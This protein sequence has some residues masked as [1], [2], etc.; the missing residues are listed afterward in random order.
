MKRLLILLL[1][2]SLL[3]LSGCSSNE[4]PDN[5]LSDELVDI[6]ETLIIDVDLPQNLPSNASTYKVSYKDFDSDELLELFHM[7]SVTFSERDAIGQRFES[8]NSLLYV[9]DDDGAL[10]GGF[11]YSK[12]TS[13]F[14][15]IDIIH[16]CQD[17]DTDFMEDNAS[18]DF[19]DTEALSFL[20]TLELEQ[21][22][23]Q[24]KVERA[25]EFSGQALNEFI[26][27]SDEFTS[28]DEGTFNPED[29]YSFVY[30][31]QFI[32]DIP[33]IT[34][35][36]GV[37]TTSTYSEA[38]VLL[39]ENHVI[40]NRFVSLYDVEQEISNGE[41][42]SPER[43]LNTFIADYNKKMQFDITTITNISLNYVVTVDK[44]GMY[45][46]P[47]YVFEYEYKAKSENEPEPVI[48]E[49]NKVIS[50]ISGEFILSTEVG[51]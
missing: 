26:K 43:A 36:W 50:A 49:E 47:A 19:S 37:G 44:N 1:T 20:E 3:L 40:D 39:S 32:N 46:Q 35:P 27:S 15:I 34:S 7:E 48:I 25:Y 16:V 17:T 12:N 31:S 33:F 22:L 11:S 13:V 45:A 14:S 38:E 10:N 2:I 8:G 9:Y 6:P 30:L 41:I 42:I 18:D 28:Q 24:L 21:G 29:H 51:I 5:K 23:G 4:L